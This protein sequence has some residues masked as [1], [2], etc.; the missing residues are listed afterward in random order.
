[1]RLACL[2][3][4][5]NRSRLAHN[6]LR[7]PLATVDPKVYLSELAPMNETETDAVTPVEGEAHPDAPSLLSHDTLMCFEGLVS[8]LLQ[9]GQVGRALAPK[10]TLFVFISTPSRPASAPVLF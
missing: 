10:C 9:L 7:L 2:F 4:F 3:L 5:T 8:L 6:L 1:M